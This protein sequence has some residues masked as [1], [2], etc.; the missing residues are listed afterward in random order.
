MSVDCCLRFFLVFFSKGPSIKDVRTEG[1]G[2]SSTD[3]H[4]A[5]RGVNFSR[6]CADIFYGRPLITILKA[7]VFR[8]KSVCLVVGRPGFDSLS[9]S[10]QKT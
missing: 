9:E 4:F 1:E 2:L 7:N 6:F 5:D 3:R 10:D 8:C